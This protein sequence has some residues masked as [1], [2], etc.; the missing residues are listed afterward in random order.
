MDTNRPLNVAFLALPEV[1][2]STLHGMFD[3]FASAGR[4]WTFL[5]EGLS[6]E[7]AARPYI[8]ARSNGP[9]TA[10]NGITIMPHYGMDD[11][12]PP[13]IL[14]VSDFFIPPEE[15]CAGKFEPEINW[16]RRC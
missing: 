16:I 11:C 14:C 2:A 7:G 12:P 1:T 8:V 9:V 15:S 13:D 4:D 6:N 3:L 10:F 5:T